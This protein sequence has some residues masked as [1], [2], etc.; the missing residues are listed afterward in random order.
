MPTLAKVV[1]VAVFLQPLTAAATC[2]ENVASCTQEREETSLLQTKAVVQHATP[3]QSKCSAAKALD[4]G[5]AN[6]CICPLGNDCGGEPLSKT[7]WFGPAPL[8]CLWSPPGKAIITGTKTKMDAD[9]GQWHF[10]LTSCP[11]CQCTNPYQAR[12][13]LPAT[14]SV[15][16]QM[17]SLAALIYQDV[18]CPKTADADRAS[19]WKTASGWELAYHN[20]DPICKNTRE[21]NKAGW[22]NTFTSRNTTEVNP[23]AHDNFA[24]F[25]NKNAKAKGV[26][27][28]TCVLAIEGTTFSGIKNWVN[29]ASPTSS[30]WCGMNVQSGFKAEI[31]QFLGN[32]GVTENEDLVGEPVGWAHYTDKEYRAD[33]AMPLDPI[34][35]NFK[36]FVTSNC[37]DLYVTGHSLGGAMAEMFAACWNSP[38][39]RPAADKSPPVS[40]VYTFGAPSAF[41]PNKIPP[42]T[43]IGTGDPMKW[44]ICFGGK[45]FFNYDTDEA[46]D[47]DPVPTIATHLGWTHLPYD[48]VQLTQAADSTAAAERT[49]VCGTQSV[50]QKNGKDLPTNTKDSRNKKVPDHCPVCLVPPTPET[51]KT[52]T[53]LHMVTEGAIGYG[54]GT[55]AVAITVGTGGAAGVI[56][57]G[58]AAIAGAG[59]GSVTSSHLSAIKHGAG[60]HS[61]T[62]YEER[63][64]Q[65]GR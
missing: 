25:I 6:K 31:M 19:F 16:A 49:T 11:E 34:V 30:P 43:R 32:W 22:I 63:L 4:A 60:L 54:L 10:D 9:W 2:H 1:T 7:T 17:A 23:T 52:T 35:G 55:A 28:K 61:M 41:D 21:N 53:L 13:E 12:R 56:V 20:S 64:A 37:N 44:D 58:G 48:A 8:G 62:V 51:A 27:P 46:G 29:D 40:R 65:N 45:R 39:H 24:L 42:R 57:A 14:A 5:V 38:W 33:L 3:A 50:P 47:F 36:Q 15:D 59:L 26:R 18:G